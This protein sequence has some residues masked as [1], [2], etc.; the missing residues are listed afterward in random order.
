MPDHIDTGPLAG[1]TAREREVLR[2]IG[3][4]AS[5]KQIARALGLSVRTVETHRLNLRRKLDVG[6]QAELLLY[7]Q[8]HMR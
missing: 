4:G 3:A 8:R 6:G 5:S 1:L 2:H 7:V